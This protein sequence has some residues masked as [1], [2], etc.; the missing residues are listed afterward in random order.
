MELLPF[1]P[2]EQALMQNSVVQTPIKGNGNKF[3]LGLGVGAIVIALV[4]IATSRIPRKNTKEQ[5]GEHS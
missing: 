5:S 2:V 3:W 1:G 4:W